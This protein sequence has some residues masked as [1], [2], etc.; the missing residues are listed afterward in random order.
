[1]NKSTRRAGWKHRRDGVRVNKRI[2]AE[3]RRESVGWA[4]WVTHDWEDKASP[5]ERYGNHRTFPRF[6]DLLIACEFYDRLQTVL[7]ESSLRQ[8]LVVSAEADAFFPQTFERS[9]A[10][11]CNPGDG[12]LL[13]D[14]KPVAELTNLSISQSDGVLGSHERVYPGL[15]G[16]SSLTAER[17]AWLAAMNL[18]LDGVESPSVAEIGRLGRE[19]DSEPRHSSSEQ[20]GTAPVTST[21]D[22]RPEP[23]MRQLPKSPDRL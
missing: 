8:A 13:I 18:K 21:W 6:N 16:S 10:C 23:T 12:T 17:Q 22:D 14:G 1:M 7:S 9:E 15:A 5:L 11:Y 4:L 19:A 20:P 2:G 3:A